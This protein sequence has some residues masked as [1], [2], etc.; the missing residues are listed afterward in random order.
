MNALHVTRE[1]HEKLWA[2][3]DAVTTEIGGFGYVRIEDGV[4]LWHDI[5]IV[6]QQVNSSNVEYTEAGMASAVE[7]AA[8]DGVLGADNMAWM[9]WHSHASMGVFYSHTD[10]ADQVEKFR[11]YT[12]LPYLFSFVGNRKHEYNARLDLWDHPMVPHISF[13]KLT[14]AVVGDRTIKDAAE[15]EIKQLVSKLQ[16]VPSGQTMSYDEYKKTNPKATYA[17]YQAAT[18]KSANNSQLGAGG[19]EGWDDKE[20]LTDDEIA[21]IAAGKYNRRTDSDKPMVGYDD[22]LVSEWWDQLDWDNDDQI[23]GA[24]KVVGDLGLD[25]GTLLDNEVAMLQGVAEVTA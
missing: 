19:W 1:V 22:I 2:Y 21:A 23:K 7:R 16:F 24:M 5:F 11:D 20:D 3:I 6:E 10:E 18:K 4:W 17:E 25:W 13:E 9:V 12:R 8:N 15:A 14:L